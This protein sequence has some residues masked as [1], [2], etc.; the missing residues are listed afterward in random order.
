MSTILVIKI[1]LAVGAIIVLVGRWIRRRRSSG[2]V[3]DPEIMRGLRLHML[4]TVPE[5][6]DASVGPD[7]PVAIIM[8]IGTP[9][10]AASVYSSIEGDASIYLT[11]GGGLL[12]GIGHD[13]VR[14][15]A[16]AFVQQAGNHRDEL[17]RTSDYPY[18]ADGNVRFYVCTRQGVYA[19]YERFEDALG[20][21][22]D[23]LWPLFYAGQ[24]VITEFRRVA[25][26]F[27][28]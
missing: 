18:P 10:G 1:A 5:Q 7:D 17:T 15:A 11:N 8:D 22:E 2:E 20:R 9:E 6:L 13:S 19:S 23:A 26:E 4:E 25:P 12:G 27:G 21:R 24:N 14:A 28:Q 3:G 16:Q